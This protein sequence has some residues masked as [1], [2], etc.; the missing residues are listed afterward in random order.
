[1]TAS[2]KSIHFAA[3]PPEP[4]W[5]SARYSPSSAITFLQWSRLVV[6]PI[7]VQGGDG[8]NCRERQKRVGTYKSPVHRKFRGANRKWLLQSKSRQQRA[9][10]PSGEYRQETA[11]DC[12]FA[13]VGT[14]P[15][16]GSG[17]QR[18]RS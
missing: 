16:R 10:S 9:T 5:T 14:N 18:T 15:L 2:S 17:A 8:V 6:A 11:Y 3:P 12:A 13:E 4:V 1:M 7:V